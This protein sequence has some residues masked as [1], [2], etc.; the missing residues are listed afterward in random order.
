[1]D[2]FQSKL[3]LFEQTVFSS[4]SEGVELA[5]EQFT[6]LLNEISLRSLRLTCRKKIQRNKIS[7]KW[8]DNDCKLAR[9]SLKVL[10]KIDNLINNKEIHEFWNYLRSIYEDNPRDKNEEEIPI[11]NLF[12][13]FTN[14]NATRSLTNEISASEDFKQDHSHLDDEISLKKIE[15]ATKLLKSK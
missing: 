8:F 10:S 5:T 1:M 12:T 11:D 3:S 6:N 7:K 2:E 15:N 14:P 9:R 13:H 4:N